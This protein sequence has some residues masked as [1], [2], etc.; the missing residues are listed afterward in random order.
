MSLRYSKC[1]GRDGFCLIFYEV[2][3]NISYKFFFLQI[4]PRFRKWG[5]KIFQKVTWA[6]LF[7]F[8]VFPSCDFHFPWS[9]QPQFGPSSVFNVHMAHLV[10][11]LY[12]QHLRHSSLFITNAL[13]LIS[14]G[15]WACAARGFP[16]S[17][18]GN[19]NLFFLYFHRGKFFFF[20]FEK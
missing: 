2:V 17:L 1:F 14:L 15:N 12:K 8:H 10:N 20:F 11:D 7:Q 19:W 4:S 16:T 6:L 5:L 13:F 3:R 9:K 18:I